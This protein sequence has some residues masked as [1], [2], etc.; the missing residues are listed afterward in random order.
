MFKLNKKQDYQTVP[1]KHIE[2]VQ[3]IPVTVTTWAKFGNI[4][5]QVHAWALTKTSYC[6]DE[7]F[8]KGTVPKSCIHEEIVGCVAQLPHEGITH[9]L[10][11]IDIDIMGVPEY[12]ITEEP[13]GTY[14]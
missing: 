9:L 14:K 4:C 8:D 13:E 6:T 5:R 1:K 11:P 10:K 3:I 7:D 2:I 12:Y